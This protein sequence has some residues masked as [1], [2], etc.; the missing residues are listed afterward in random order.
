MLRILPYLAGGLLLSASAFAGGYLDPLAPAH[1]TT[2]SF[3]ARWEAS[4]AIVKRDSARMDRLA[5]PH[6][7]QPQAITT[8][9]LIGLGNAGVI[10]R[11]QNG[12]V[13]FRNDP[14]TQTTTV[15]KGVVVPDL[16]IRRNPPATPRPAPA[17]RDAARD[18]PL[19]LPEACES[20]FSP[21]AAPSL[22]DIMGRCF[23]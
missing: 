17:A 18:K 15:A 12:R 23:A 19:K 5:A 9:E 1:R 7:A 16:T 22:A 14:G 13:L 2:A 10:Y 6:A 4:G 21:V 20:A 3:D 11:D 8:I